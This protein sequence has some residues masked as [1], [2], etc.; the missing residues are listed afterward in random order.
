MFAKR[1]RSTEDF[2]EEVQAHIRLEEER[3]RADGM[4]ADEARAA[5]RREFGSAL[6]AQERFAESNG[7]LWWEQFRRDLVFAFRMLRRIP[8]FSLIA[9][10]SLAL[11]IGANAVVF[12]IVNL[13]LLQPLP[14]QDPSRVVFLE[15]GQKG[16]FGSS[17]S[18]GDYLDVRDRNQ[19]LSGMAAYRMAPVDIETPSGARRAWSLLASGSYFDML[20]IRPALGRFFHQEEDV[21]IGAS[22]LAVLSYACWQSRFAGDSRIIGATIRINRHPFTV[23]GVA[24][25]EFHG[26]EL[27]FWPDVWVPITMEP[28]IESG[29]PWINERSSGNAWVIGRLKPGVTPAQATANLNAIAVE[30][31]RAYPATDEGLQFKLAQPGMAG[32]LGRSPVRAFSLGIQVLAALVLLAACINLASLVLAR[33]SDRRREI[34]IRLSIGAS[35]GRVVRQ[36]LTESV[37][38]AFLGGVAGYGLAV[39]LAGALSSWRAPMDFP[40]Q[41]AIHPDWRVLLFTFSITLAAGIIFGLAPARQAARTDANAVL[42]GE[43]SGWRRRVALRDVLVAAQVALCFVLVSGCLLSLYGLERSIT[44]DLGFDPRN[45]SV[46][47]FDLGLAGYSESA[48]RAFQRQA[49]EQV[50]QIPGVT[51]A[52]YSNSVPLSIDQSNSIV[53]SEDHPNPRLRDAETASFF[54]VSPGF[55]HAMGIRMLAGREFTWH[56][57]IRAPHVA[58]VNRAFARQVMHSEDAIGKR[59]RRGPGGDLIQIV[60]ITE[61][62]KYQSLTE[63]ARPAFFESILYQY[64]PTTTL[65]VR[66]SLPAEEMNARVREVISRIDPAMP[67]YG[68]GSLQHMLGFAM[69]PMHAAAVALS[70]FGLLAIMLA[71]TGIYGLVSYSVAR[72][73][74]EIGIRVAVGASR[75]NVALLVL[76]RIALLLLLGCAVGLALSLAAGQ[77]LSSLVYGVS[78]RDPILLFAVFLVIALLGMASSLVPVRRALNISP[79]SAL[80]H[81]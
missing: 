8:G 54:E 19:T 75:M 33:A 2:A 10:F 69:F 66:S 59:F 27:F 20:G 64:N 28:Q 12:S 14:I 47:G 57:D 13:F 63:D 29:N 22:P 76:S 25:P 60:G 32:D 15:A 49:L 3:F 61:D 34:A 1:R 35:R 51:S 18:Y 80:R 41:F 30:I 26:T 4:S 43:E 81:E 21:K 24:P 48:G 23:V 78:P 37:F 56:D 11:G 40:V 53:V 45:V 5:A 70:A 9:V 68:T 58:I 38:L 67:L 52:A 31:A 74:R 77:V 73:V 62:G 36:L 55:F 50:L 16:N 71:V 7:W 42:K 44:M 79:V 72:R 65:I 6:A 17:M 46:A 39:V